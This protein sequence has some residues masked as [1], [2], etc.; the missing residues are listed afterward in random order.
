VRLDELTAVVGD[1]RGRPGVAVLTDLLAGVESGARSRAERLAQQVLLR[2]GLAGWQWN[3]P[4][5]LPD[6][7]VAVVDAALPH[8]R[9]AV[10]IDGRAFHSDAAAFQRDRTRQNALV[11]AGWTVL[12]FTWSDLV[13]RPDLIVATVLAAAARA[14]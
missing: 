12:R 13:H 8:L 11:A 3:H 10:E 2:T 1:Q 4:V 7:G 5:A 9:I 14:S 6:G